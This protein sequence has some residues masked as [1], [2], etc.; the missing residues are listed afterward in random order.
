MESAVKLVFNEKPIPETQQYK[1]PICITE[2]TYFSAKGFI[3]EAKLYCGS[4]LISVI[5]KEYPNADYTNDE[6][7]ENELDFLSG[8][9]LHGA[10]IKQPIS[11]QLKCIGDRMPS[12]VM[13]P[14]EKNLTLGNTPL[15][16][17]ELIVAHSDK[18][19]RQ[20]TISYGE[21]V[22]YLP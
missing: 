20:L 10:L 6:L 8:I 17:T 15:P 1:F 14:A 13:R 5:K 2:S 21:E 19:P 18:G 11:I 7:P 22:G 12:I 4:R 9:P 16:Y 3:S